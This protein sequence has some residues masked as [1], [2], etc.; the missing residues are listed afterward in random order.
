[1]V[2]RTITG[3]TG[4]DIGTSFA[5][6][7]TELA[8]RSDSVIIVAIST[9]AVRSSLSVWTACITVAAGCGTSQTLVIALATSSRVIKIAINTLASITNQLSKVSTSVTFSAVSRSYITFIACWITSYTI[10]VGPIIE[11]T[12][13]AWTRRPDLFSVCCT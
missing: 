12:W 6:I 8:C 10:L 7:I 1:M 5:R 4:T 9:I 2:G 13:F 3:V 11:V